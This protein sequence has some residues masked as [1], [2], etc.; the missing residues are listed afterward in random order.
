MTK[1]KFCKRPN[2][3]EILEKKNLWSLNKEELNSLTPQLNIS[4]I[5]SFLYSMINS[6]L[7]L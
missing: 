2:C 1:I 3:E 7:K 6:K 4:E 5:N